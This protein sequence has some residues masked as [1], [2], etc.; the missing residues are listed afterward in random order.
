MNNTITNKA[1]VIVLLAFSSISKAY[2]AEPIPSYDNKDVSI[3]TAA[4]ECQRNNTGEFGIRLCLAREME[5]WDSELN[6]VYQLLMDGFNSDRQRI[7]LRSVQRV[8]LTYRDAEFDYINGRYEGLSG[9]MY[10]TLIKMQK[11]RIVKSRVKH[12]IYLL[13]TQEA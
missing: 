7:N 3:E 10:P 9:S 4:V 13:K 5:S 11:I 1:I 12:L 2:S 6:R 8:W